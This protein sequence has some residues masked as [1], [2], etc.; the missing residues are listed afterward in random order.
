MIYQDLSEKITSIILDTNPGE[1]Q[2]K[3][4]GVCMRAIV[5]GPVHLLTI[6]GPALFA[7]KKKSLTLK[8]RLKIDKKGPAHD[9]NVFWLPVPQLIEPELHDQVHMHLF[10]N[11]WSSDHSVPRFIEV[12]ALNHIHFNPCPGS[13]V[14]ILSM[15]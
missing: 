8:K 5:P 15:L 9:Q 13:T 2:S 10:Q 14:L 12:S 1:Q 11:I 6:W 7:K 4:R 3:K